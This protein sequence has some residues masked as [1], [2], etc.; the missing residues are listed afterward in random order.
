MA[1]IENHEYDKAIEQLKYIRD[2]KDSVQLIE[3]CNQRI[4]EIK[5]ITKKKKDRHTAIAFLSIV[6]AMIVSFLILVVYIVAHYD[7]GSTKNGNSN[8]YKLTFVLNGGEWDYGNSKN[9]HVGSASTLP[10]PQK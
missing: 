10:S 3:K 1:Y 4:N 9:Y 7:L 6:V 8:H 2:Y 5:Q